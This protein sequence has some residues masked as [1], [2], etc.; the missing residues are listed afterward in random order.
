MTEPS[1]PSLP[2]NPARRSLRINWGVLLA[3][4]AMALAAVSWLNGRDDSRGVKTDLARKLAEFDASIK[5]SQLLARN[6]DELTR[7]NSTRLAQ[8]ESQLGGSKEQQQAL[9]SL[10]KELARDRDQWALSDIEQIVLTAS[11][12]IQLAGNIKAA[13]LGLETADQRLLRL[14]KP[15]FTRLRQAIGNDL[16]RLRATPVVDQTGISLRLNALADNIDQWPLSSA[17]TKTPAKDSKAKPTLKQDLL[18][19]FK[20]LIQIRRLD[21]GEPALLTPEQEY[22]LRQN[23][24]LRLL[25]ARLSLLSRDAAGYQADLQ[26]AGKLLARYFNTQ[27]SAVAAAQTELHKLAVLNA[28]PKLPELKESLAAIESY[29]PASQ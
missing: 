27:D 12:Q 22:F 20:N 8:V 28:S 9:E 29:H 16:A 24:K 26:T 5:E 15:Q 23:L 18:S 6:A 11:Q 13:I 17:H 2:A 3:V 10:Y 14:D 4:L 19:E 25:T 21:Q 7:Q 1:T